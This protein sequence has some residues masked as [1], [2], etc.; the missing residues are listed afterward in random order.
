MTV[1]TLK[2]TMLDGRFAQFPVL[3]LLAIGTAGISCY[4]KRILYVVLLLVFAVSF[5]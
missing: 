3:L 1:L 2:V 5:C 4:V